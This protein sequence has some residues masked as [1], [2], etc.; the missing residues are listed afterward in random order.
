MRCLKAPATLLALFLRQVERTLRRLIPP[1]GTR[2]SFKPSFIEERR[3]SCHSRSSAAQL[4]L[5]AKPANDYSRRRPLRPIPMLFSVSRGQPFCRS[6]KG[7]SLGLSDVQ[8]G[9]PLNGRDRMHSP[10]GLACCC[11]RNTARLRACARPCDAASLQ[12]PP[13]L[14]WRNGTLRA[15][16]AVSGLAAVASEPGSHVLRSQSWPLARGYG[17]P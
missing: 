15:A 13:P 5:R 9:S 3:G 7:R 14:Y 8:E 16:V 11:K 1:S 6:P 12:N 17:Y 2:C 10:R 4:V